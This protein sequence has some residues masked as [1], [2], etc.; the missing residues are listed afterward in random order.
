MQ[1][2]GKDKWDAIISKQ[3]D[4]LA[5]RIWKGNSNFMLESF[6]QQHRT[7]HIQM[8]AAA[9]HVPHQL[10][11]EYTQV[12]DLLCKIQCDDAA[13]QA[14]MANLE[15]DDG[16]GGKRH[17]FEDAASFLLPKDPVTKRINNAGMK[18]TNV[19]ISNVQIELAGFGAK[20]G[21][22]HTGVHLRYHKKPEYSKLT[23]EQKGELKEWRAGQPDSGKSPVKRFK[24]KEKRTRAFT[25]AVEKAVNKHLG[26]RSQVPT[27]PSAQGQVSAAVAATQ[28]HNILQAIMNSGHKGGNVSSLQIENPTPASTSEQSSAEEK[29]AADGKKAERRVTFDESARRA[30]SRRHHP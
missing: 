26:E 27:P 2:A 20:P 30:I 7:A 23:T 22:G 3:K 10:P 1:Y 21:I 16:P 12:T 18:R 8:A 25:S 11:D 5:T 9:E 14:A 19:S 15:N 17:N 29:T 13:L 4:I 28:A 6:V 24:K